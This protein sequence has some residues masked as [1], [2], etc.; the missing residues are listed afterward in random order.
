MTELG[1]PTSIDSERLAL[2]RAY[3]VGGDL[4]ARD[5]LIAGLLPLV[6]SLARRYA[7][8]GEDMEDLVQAGSVGLIKAV[9]R[10]D[11][12]RDVPLVS[13][14]FPTVLGELKRHFRDHAWALS[15]PR[16]LKEMN[17]VLSRHLGE[18]TATLGRSPT[19]VELAEATDLDPE[20]VLEAMEAGRAYTAR[21]LSGQGEDE[22]E[23]LLDIIATLGDE[24]QGYEQ[25]EDRAA[26]AVGFR[27]LDERERRILH[28][29]F[30]E[31]LTQTQIAAEIGISQMHVSRLIRK[32]LKQL[33][34]EIES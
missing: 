13:Y 28:L 17:L 34:E 19:I 22:D 31:G 18:L 24:E 4:A 29:R 11:L 25:T 10:F 32:A 26:L 15:V 20:E 7:G 16:R 27:L 6:R 14:V 1:T 2:L 3:R 9:D 23:P 12:S 5:E 8:R 21:S 30:F 33:E